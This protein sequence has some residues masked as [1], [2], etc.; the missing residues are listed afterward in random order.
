MAATVTRLLSS[1]KGRN[2]TLRRREQVYDAIEG[3]MTG[4]ESCDMKARG[5]D[6]DLRSAYL[7]GTLVEGVASALIIDASFAPLI[8]DRVI[9]CDSELAILNIGP[10]KVGGVTVAY[11]LQLGK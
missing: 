4:Q 2:V 5:A 3:E 8:T 10:I 9:D 11:T 7:P 1:D 6:I